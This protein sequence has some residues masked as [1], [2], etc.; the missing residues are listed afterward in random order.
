MLFY[1]LFFNILLFIIPLFTPIN[2]VNV[3]NSSY[4]VKKLNIY[5]VNKD[6]IKHAIAAFTKF[7]NS[8][9]KE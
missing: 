3:N 8:I 9:S 5:K 7:L 2:N 1:L 4:V 6:A